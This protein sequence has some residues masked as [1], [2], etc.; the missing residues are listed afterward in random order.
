M[1]RSVRA[2][3]GRRT[4]WPTSSGP[5]GQSSP[6][7]SNV[8]TR[9]LASASMIDAAKPSSASSIAG[10]ST[11]SRGSR[12][13]TSCRASQPSTAPGTCTLR[14]SR[15]TRHDRVALGAQPRRVGARARPSDRQ[16]GGRRRSRGRHHGQHVAP[17]AAQV[18]AHHRHHGARAHGG[19]GG[20]AA[21]GQQPD[22]G[23]G[24]QLVG[25][26]HH[27]PRGV[28]WPERGERQRHPIT[29]AQSTT[30]DRSTSPRCMRAKASSTPSMPMVSLT[31]RSRSSR[32]SR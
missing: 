22:P 28:A 25:G 30:T 18:R 15:R 21:A 12:P 26:G 20:R 5:S 8:C 4:R 2:R 14:M 23:R 27:A 29:P 24:G 17:E 32:P 6:A 7:P 19:V 10:A 13:K 31:K 11:S 1:A 16:Q 3:P 9:W